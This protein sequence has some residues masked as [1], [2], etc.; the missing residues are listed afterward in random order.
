ML[1]T[2]SFDS[3]TVD[4]DAKGLDAGDENVNAEVKLASS[5]QGRQIHIPW[6]GLEEIKAMMDVTSVP[7]V[8]GCERSGYHGRSLSKISLLLDNF[9]KSPYQLVQ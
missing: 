1:R 6:R 3:L 2:Q 8:H 9:L 7:S 5:D 4:V